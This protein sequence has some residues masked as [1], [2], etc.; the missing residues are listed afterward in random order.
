MS[1]DESNGEL[2]A[3]ALV[4]MDAEPDEDDAK[5]D[6]GL[7]VVEVEDES[8]LDPIE[9][10]TKAAL[11]MSGLT[12]ERAFAIDNKNLGITLGEF[13]MARLMEIFFDRVYKDTD[14]WF[15]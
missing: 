9:K 4:A 5:D 6:E 14:E 12:Y 1:D 3:G 8:H 13:T 15:R 10:L 2:D 7:I 11:R